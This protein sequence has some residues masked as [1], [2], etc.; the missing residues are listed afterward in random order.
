MSLSNHS[1]DFEERMTFL[2]KVP[3][4]KKLPNYELPRLADCCLPEVY[5]PDQYVV[6]QGDMGHEFFVIQEGAAAVHVLVDVTDPITGRP[7]KQKENKK[8]ATLGKGDYF[9]ENALLR[10]EARTAS[11][12]AESQGLTCLVL[13]RKAFQELGLSD[14]LRFGNRRGISVGAKSKAKPPTNKTPEDKRLIAE[15]LRNNDAISSV[16][17]LDDDMIEEVIKRMWKEHVDEG[18][19]LIK[20][21]DV[22]TSFFYVVQ[23]GSFEISAEERI[24]AK[25]EATSLK[26]VNQSGRG[27]SFGELA[28]LYCS[29]RECNVVAK[30]DSIVWVLD[31]ASFKQILMKASDAKIRLYVAILDTVPIFSTLLGEEKK[32]MAMAL[33]EIHFAAGEDIVK[34]GDT[35]STFYLLFDGKVDIYKVG[36]GVVHTME[37]DATRKTTAFFGERALLANEK[38][39]ATVKVVSDSAK[40]LAL[41]RDAFETLLGPLRDIIEDTAADRKAAAAGAQVKDLRIPDEPTEKVCY[42][43]LTVVGLLGCGGFGIVEA[44]EHRLTG[45]IYA[46]KSMNKATILMNGM[47]KAVM[48]ERNVLTMTNS[49][50]IIRLWDTYST[51]QH[52]HYLMEVCL[53]GDL[54][55]TFARK[56]LHGSEKHTKYYAASIVL[57]FRHLHERRIIYRDLKPENILLSREGYAKLADMS[58]AKFV[59]GKTYTTCGT[60]DYFAPEVIKAE[61]HNEALDWWTL[62]IFIFELL[63]QYTPFEDP[64]GGR[65]LVH[66]VRII[67]GIN[68]VIFPVNCRGNAED[69]IKALC[70]SDPVQRLPMKG[71]GFEKLKAHRFWSGLNWNALNEGRLFPPF[72]PAIKHKRDLSNFAVK[73]EDRPKT[74]PAYRDPMDGWDANFATGHI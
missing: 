13:R 20:V 74:Q 23:N 2:Q 38:R 61:G 56:C 62:G 11:I 8:V 17:P 12:I 14:K 18:T 57:A 60:P 4:F 27:S 25:A 6:K 16:V 63:S 42:S 52:L 9:G 24:N 50:F 15:A 7:K 72:R 21:R 69:L 51:D 45:A 40:V 26:V 31:R 65:P 41:D 33:T 10:D 19:V 29:P 64:N 36:I 47:R 35:G 55:A 70:A 54:H 73:E 3:L 71:H 1:L 32:T 49:P 28:L 34:E 22:D 68:D 43:D 67:K 5:M 46:L 30:K 59:I 39:G 37:A 48:A 53:G 44:V 58:L 66:F